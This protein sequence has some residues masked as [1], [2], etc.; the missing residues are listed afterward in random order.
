[1]MMSE[2]DETKP[3]LD[4]PLGEA[5]TRDTFA[6]E[7]P[8]IMRRFALFVDGM[9]RALILPFGPDLVHRLVYKTSEIEATSWSGVSYYMGWMVSAYIV[10]RWLGSMLSAVWRLSYDRLPK[11]VARLGGIAVSLHVF[12]YGAGLGSV[13]ILVAIRFLSAILAGVLCGITNEISLPEDEWSFRSGGKTSLEEER[14]NAMR[15]REGY[16]DIASGTAK[17][18]LTGFAVSILSGGLLFRQATKDS[19]FQALTGAYQYSWSPLFLIVLTVTVEIVLRGI[20]FLASNP[21]VHIEENKARGS[22]QGSAQRMV[23]EKTLRP[24]I[25]ERYDEEMSQ[26]SQPMSMISERLSYF[27]ADAMTQGGRSRKESYTSIDDFF[28]CHSVLSDVEE[29]GFDDSQRSSPADAAGA[30]CAYIGKRCVY[31]DGSPSFVPPGECIAVV[32]EH[33]LK[34][35][36][37]NEAR[38]RKAWEKTQEWRR[39]KNIWRIHDLS[40][41]WFFKIKEAYPHYVHGH[42]KQGYP[43]VYEKPGKMR[44][45]EMF[46]EGIETADMVKHLTFFLEYLSIRLS[47]SNE[48]LS[49]VGKTEKPTAST[50]GMMVVMD[51]QGLG[52]SHIS[53]D[54]LSYLKQ[55]SAVNSDHYP[56]AMKRAFLI[57]SP[58][59]LAGAWSGLKGILPDTVQVDILSAHNY[60]PAISEYIDEDQIPPEYGGTSPYSLGSH[61]Y[62]NAMQQLVEESMDNHDADTAPKQNQY[63][64]TKTPPPKSVSVF[65]QPPSSSTLTPSPL[66]PKRRRVGSQDRKNEPNSTNFSEATNSSSTCSGCR[67]VFLLVSSIHFLWSTVQGAIELAIPLWILSPTNMGG[68]GYSPSRSGVSLFT[69]CLVLLAVLRSRPSRMVSKIPSKSPLRALRIG[70]GSESVLLVLLTC[71]T[72]FVP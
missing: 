11:N 8:S 26:V 24:L 50:W 30:I 58:F 19:T 60:L 5:D 67:E 56:M 51:L 39:E 53:G 16:V 66:F 14:M 32:P 69:A 15:R 20:F 33:Y 57:N 43:V 45:K 65:E 18:Y 27:D 40:N 49:A 23:T 72:C 38:A 63:L 62:E 28:D 37:S 42:T 31:P 25:E 52:V 21:G 48:I 54:V 7:P 22:F 44:I 41:R 29:V 71:I 35:Y 47:T 46:R 10:G 12:T 9:A 36:N 70:A 34:F 2:E 55:A 13:K 17:I 1:M 3:F 59:W 64:S 68:L 6:T 4:V 61:P